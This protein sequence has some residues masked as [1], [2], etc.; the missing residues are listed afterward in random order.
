MGRDGTGWCPRSRSTLRSVSSEQSELSTIATQLDELLARVTT[1]G[2][3][4]NHDDT[5]GSALSLFEAERALRTAQRA[6]ERA[7]AQLL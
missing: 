3:R 5:E 6:V 1:V 4:L 7:Q 2:E